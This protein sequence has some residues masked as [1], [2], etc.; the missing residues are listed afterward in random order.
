LDEKW[1]ACLQAAI[2]IFNLYYCI[3]G[4]MMRLGIRFEG[5]RPRAAIV[6]GPYEPIITDGSYRDQVGSSVIHSERS[7]DDSSGPLAKALVKQQQLEALRIKQEE[8]RPRLQYLMD[9][10]EWWKKI[11]GK[12]P[13]ENLLELQELQTLFDVPGL[14][15][16]PNLTSRTQPL[17]DS[18]LREDSDPGEGPS[19][20]PASKVRLNYSQIEVLVDHIT[21]C[22]LVGYFSKRTKRGG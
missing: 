9:Q 15:D 12:F 7:A 16:Q 4:Q 17:Y 14:R 13:P 2:S 11:G 22:K 18:E 19:H 6:Y 5:W 8:A 21:N 3:G 1:L 10:Q 20:P